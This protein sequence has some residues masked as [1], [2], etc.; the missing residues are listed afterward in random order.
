MAMEVSE[1]GWFGCRKQFCMRFGGRESI[2]QVVFGGCGKLEMV[3]RRRVRR[4]VK[5]LLIE[6]EFCDCGAVCWK[7]R[8]RQVFECWVLISVEVLCL[9]HL[10]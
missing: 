7:G 10:R 4:D 5:L 9:H 6:N 3:I 2:S 1:F 8:R